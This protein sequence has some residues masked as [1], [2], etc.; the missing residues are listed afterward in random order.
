MSDKKA[1]QCLEKEF[2]T[3]RKIRDVLAN[4]DKDSEQV[5]IDGGN[6]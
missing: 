4:K 5:V 1:K 6:A 3:K 2:Y